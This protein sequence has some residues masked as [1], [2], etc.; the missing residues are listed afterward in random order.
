LKLANTNVFITVSDAI[1]S[2]YP[3][4]YIQFEAILSSAN[5]TTFASFL[6][7]WATLMGVAQCDTETAVFS[8][9]N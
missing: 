3:Q 6:S 8:A 5:D 7:G 2:N 4:Q 9:G 1:H